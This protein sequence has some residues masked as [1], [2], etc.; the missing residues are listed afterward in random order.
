MPHLAIQNK[1]L[2]LKN[3]PPY[4]QGIL[5]DTNELINVIFE[6]NSLENLKSELFLQVFMDHF[7]TLCKKTI[8]LFKDAKEI[9][10][11]PESEYRRE[12]TRVSLP[13]MCLLR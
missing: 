4:L 5:S 10:E 11:D 8:K 1:R 12:L 2:N 13:C 3:S 9:M 7:S 6:Q